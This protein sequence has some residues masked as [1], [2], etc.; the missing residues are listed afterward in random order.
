MLLLALA[1]ALVGCKTE[2]LKVGQVQEG[3]D[4][5]DFDDPPDEALEVA[6][7]KGDVFIA[8]TGVFQITDGAEQV[9][10]VLAIVAQGL[11][12]CSVGLAWFD[13]EHRALH[14]F[15]AGTRVLATAPSSGIVE[16]S[17]RWKSHRSFHTV[18]P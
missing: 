18:D 3:C 11:V 12:L 2:A 4:D 6:V 13:R 7:E 8:H 1:G 14:D 10:V 17:S 15:V 5:Y 16:G 9:G